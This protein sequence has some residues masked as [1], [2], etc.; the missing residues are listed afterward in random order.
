MIVKL[1]TLPLG[2]TAQGTADYQASYSPIRIL[3]NKFY[4]RQQTQ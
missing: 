2:F 1:V 4:F 3:Q